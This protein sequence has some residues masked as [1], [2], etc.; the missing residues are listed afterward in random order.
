MA[1]SR[2]RPL[3][4]IPD[5]LTMVAATTAL[6]LW[7]RAVES[8]PRASPV[9]AAVFPVIMSR[10]LPCHSEK[11][12][13]KPCLT[14]SRLETNRYTLRTSVRMSLTRSLDSTGIPEY[15]L[16]SFFDI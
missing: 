6:L 8:I 15:H 10:M 2:G 1:A 13:L 12:S 5:I 3:A 14:P 11:M 7:T 9:M 16:F 4:T